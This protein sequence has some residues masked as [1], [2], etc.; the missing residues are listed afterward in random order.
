MKYDRSFIQARSACFLHERVKT[1][2]PGLC[3]DVVDKNYWY[4]ESENSGLD[5]VHYKNKGGVDLFAKE[6]TMGNFKA[7]I[8]DYSKRIKGELDK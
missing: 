6:I 8:C 5:Y 3:E 2:L 7:C 4:V 1:T